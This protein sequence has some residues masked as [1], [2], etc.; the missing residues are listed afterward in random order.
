MFPRNGKPIISVEE[1]VAT[2]WAK[3]TS[4]SVGM[5]GYGYSASNANNYERFQL[6]EKGIAK[7]VKSYVSRLED[8]T[9]VWLAGSK[10]KIDLAKSNKDWSGYHQ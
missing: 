4:A 10:S 8:S 9:V 6:D 5:V 7:R 2:A 1:Y 3:Y